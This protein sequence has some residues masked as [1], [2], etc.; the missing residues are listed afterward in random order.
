MNTIYP[1]NY[2]SSFN[3]WSA[4]IRKCVNEYKMSNTQQ[5]EV[6]KVE[7]NLNEAR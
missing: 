6:T 2:C 7:T 1:N 3:E 5:N 4:Y